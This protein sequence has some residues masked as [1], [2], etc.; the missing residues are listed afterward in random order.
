MK[1]IV[2]LTES[3]LRHVI[4]ESVKKIINEWE[5]LDDEMGVWKERSKDEFSRILKRIE[6]YVIDMFG[7]QK[8]EYGIETSMIG[9]L[10]TAYSLDGDR[11]PIAR[12]VTNILD[13]YDMLNNGNEKLDRLVR[14][15]NQL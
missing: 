14:K 5:S 1:K 4:T 8:D 2:K 9:H 6:K 11:G 10:I 12:E 15:L 13:N 3:D 7:T